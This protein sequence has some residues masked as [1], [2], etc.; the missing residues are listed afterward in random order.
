MAT[1]E[2]LEDSGY[3]FIILDEKSG[4]L[5]L[6]SPVNGNE[7]FI[8]CINDMNDISEYTK[9]YFIIH[10]GHPY[11]YI[12]KLTRDQFMSITDASIVHN[13][14]MNTEKMIELLNKIKPV[15][16][17]ELR[18]ALM[19]PEPTIIEPWR[20]E[21]MKMNNCPQRQDALNDQ[22]RDLVRVANKLGFYDAADYI[23][24]RLNLK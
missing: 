3:T 23:K 12:S 11:E 2:K 24:N 9:G 5:I 22:L 19:Q 8:R 17:P 21:Y 6:E 10:D 4:E 14:Q 15:K 20:I 7:L 1:I 13:M 18:I 16:E